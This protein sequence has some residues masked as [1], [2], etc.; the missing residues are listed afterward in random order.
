MRYKL[1]MVEPRMKTAS[2]R[3]ITIFRG[4]RYPSR[5]GEFGRIDERR[6]ALLT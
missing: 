2:L 4:Y 5:H 3:L 6:D 1:G